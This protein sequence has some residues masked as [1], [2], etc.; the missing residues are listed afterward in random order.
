MVAQ[1]CTMLRPACRFLTYA[2]ACALAERALAEG[3]GGIVLLDLSAVR[4]T[5]TAALARLIVLRQHLLRAGRDLHVTGLS[6][7]AED[8][9]HVC[10][11]EGILP[12]GGGGCFSPRLDDVDDSPCPV[13]ALRTGRAE[14][15]P[16]FTL[17][18]R[19]A[20]WWKRAVE[21]SEAGN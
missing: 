1:N 13:P 10:R 16:R 18:R 4:E 8:L 5:T 7:R 17:G 19:L 21:Q 9:Y 11:L 14:S 6:G 15:A 2:E 20:I 12:R 3:P